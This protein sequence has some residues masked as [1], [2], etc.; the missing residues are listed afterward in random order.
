MK[1]PDKIYLI[2]MQISPKYYT[3]NF[4]IFEILHFSVIQCKTFEIHLKQHSKLTVRHLHIKRIFK[5]NY[6]S[7][8]ERSI[9]Q[10]SILQIEFT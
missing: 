7:V 9:H 10:I 6:N 5:E 1:I 8:G 2:R 3:F 4:L